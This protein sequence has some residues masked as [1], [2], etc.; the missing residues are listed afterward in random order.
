MKIEYINYATT[1]TII[2]IRL[3]HNI[4]QLYIQYNHKQLKYCLNYNTYY[5]FT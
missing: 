4:N 3:N 5:V 2:Y 1:R